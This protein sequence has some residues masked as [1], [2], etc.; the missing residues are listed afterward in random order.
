MSCKDCMLCVQHNEKTWHC[1]LNPPTSTP[2]L[3]S[4]IAGGTPRVIGY[5]TTYPV[6]DLEKDWCSKQAKKPYDELE[7]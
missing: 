4:T 3:G 1:H 5:V 2:L 7:N 6:V